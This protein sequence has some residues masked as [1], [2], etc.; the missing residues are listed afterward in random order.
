M[1]PDLVGRTPEASAWL[2]RTLVAQE[3]KGVFG[4]FKPAV[5][6]TDAT[7]EDGEPLLALNPAALVAQI[8]AEPFPLRVGHDP[9]RPMGAMVAAEVFTSPEGECFVA[10]ILGFYDGAPSIAFRD[11][12]FDQLA[13][14]A[15]PQRLPALPHDVGIG[16]GVDPRQVDAAWV[17]ELI[18][19]APLPVVFDARSYNAAEPS[20]QIVNVAV[21]FLLLVWNPVSKAVFEAMG[22]D[23][24]AAVHAW[25]RRLF[26]RLARLQ[27]PILEIQSTQRGCAVSFMIRGRD[28]AQNYKAHD[29]LSEAAQRTARLID[30][31]IAADLAPK[32]LVY[33]FDTASGVWFPAFAELVDG[34]LMTDNAELISAEHIPI[35]LSLG[36]SI[37]SLS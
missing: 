37:K 29:A 28:V 3:G 17:N 35:G 9:G 11:I 15:P 6:W 8:N 24:Y 16:L 5:I 25:L 13:L 36:V 21:A 23:A 10:A 14:D 18:G 7:G 2:E 4:Q 22:K 31:M 34:R 19:D 26:D 32:R 30:H 1:M 20:H 12:G 27:D 33:E